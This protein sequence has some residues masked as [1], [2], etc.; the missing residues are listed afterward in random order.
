MRGH[1]ESNPKM[2]LYF[3]PMK[4]KQM[5]DINFQLVAIRL[6]YAHFLDAF[7]T[8]FSPIRIWSSSLIVNKP[9]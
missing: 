1:G 2:S 8:V 6:I 4:F 9:Y 5:I 7:S 3:L